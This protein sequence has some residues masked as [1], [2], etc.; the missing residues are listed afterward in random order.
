MIQTKQPSS[1]IQSGGSGN[2]TS[3]WTPGIVA[4]RSGNQGNTTG[5]KSS[6]VLEKKG[7]AETFSPRLVD[8]EFLPETDM[9]TVNKAVRDFLQH[10]QERWSVQ[11]VPPHPHKVTHRSQSGIKHITLPGEWHRNRNRAFQESET[12]GH[13]SPFWLPY[14]EIGGVVFDL[15]KL[16]LDNLVPA[17]LL[18]DN[19]SQV[20]HVPLLLLMDN[21]YQRAPRPVAKLLTDMDKVTGIAA[22]RLSLHFINELLIGNIGL[23]SLH[24]QA[25][26]W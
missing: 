10:I 25:A 3:G 19:Q 4:T 1:K 15:R 9:T 21:Q 20:Q 26:D 2:R 24:Q 6:G 13:F 22:I 8:F 11:P 16:V 14:R 7:R 12:C 17:L 23:P 5:G 18:L